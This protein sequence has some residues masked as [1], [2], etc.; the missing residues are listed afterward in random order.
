MEGQPCANGGFPNLASKY[1][2]SHNFHNFTVSRDSKDRSNNRYM[3]SIEVRHSYFSKIFT[4]ST[5]AA[6]FQVADPVVY[7]DTEWVS[8]PLPWAEFHV[9]SS[10]YQHSISPCRLI[11]MKLLQIVSLLL[12]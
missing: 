10:G 12:L 6:W 7:G 4:S 8:V 1:E 11:L 5:Y 9:A 3:K 2:G